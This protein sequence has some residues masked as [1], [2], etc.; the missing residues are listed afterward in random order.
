MDNNYLVIDEESIKNK[1]YEIRGKYVM[2]DSDLAHIYGYETKDFNRQVKNNIER[3]DYDF[4]FQLTPVELEE[5]S[6]CKNFTLNKVSGR[7]HNIKY[8]PYVFTEQGIYMLMTVLKGDIAVKQSKALIRIFKGMKDYILENRYLNSYTDIIDLALKTEHN[9]EEIKRIKTELKVIHKYLD[10]GYNKEVL[11]LNG[12]QVESDMA[13][14]KI[15]SL[16]KNSIYIIDNYIN[17]KTLVLLKD[18]DAKV[19]ITIFSDN[20]SKKLHKIEYEDFLTEYS[21]VDISF[22]ITNNRYHD[23]YIILDY[24]LFSEKIFHCGSS[25]KDSGNRITTISEISDIK[26][27]SV[28]INDLI[29]ND[30]LVLT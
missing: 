17:L 15:Y 3:F 4:M 23:R 13:Y 30:E 12:K 26:L 27:Y 6:R 29:N 1:I 19:K 24:G 11:I 7:G 22:K 9:K 14:K 10:A 5:L 8:M 18:V 28:I 16:A 2:L 21:N 20:V 25:S